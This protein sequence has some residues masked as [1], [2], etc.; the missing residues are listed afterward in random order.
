MQISTRQYGYRWLAAFTELYLELKR[1]V[2]ERIQ[3]RGDIRWPRLERRAS[4]LIERVNEEISKITRR[5]TLAQSS[6]GPLEG[7]SFEHVPL[8]ISRCGVGTAAD[9]QAQG[10]WVCAEERC[11]WS[12]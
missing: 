4:A 10:T 2:R 5:V 3:H 6:S 12:V 8:D 9:G 1:I 7:R 11:V